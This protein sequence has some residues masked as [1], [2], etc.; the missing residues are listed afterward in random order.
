[1]HTCHGFPDFTTPT[2]VKLVQ[3]G[4]ARSFANALH[5][6]TTR[7]PITPAIL[8]HI[9]ALWLPRQYE[10]DTIMLWAALCTAF[11]GFLRLGEMT[12]P[13]QTS[14]DPAIHL[15]FEDVSVDNPASPKVISLTIKQSK[16][17]QLRSGSTVN[18][19]IT[20]NALCPVA[21]LLAYLAIRGN[22]PG[23]LFLFADGKFL[24]PA[25][26]VQLMRSALSSLGLD[27][28]EFAG[29]SLWIG[30]AT[31][32]AS[33]G[34]QDSMIKS[35]GRWRSNAYQRYIR[36]SNKDLASAASRLAH[37]PLPGR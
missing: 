11:F 4:A 24:T 27:P 13:S 18:L 37:Q 6:S 23:P 34:I 7:L 17:D 30:A 12:A 8:T 19:T 21:A 16:T 28:T 32:A 31:T 33:V 25:A 26:L 22:M 35:L 10:R 5:H 9:R 1:M 15:C 29:H 3:K 2:A 20:S 36:P 14:Y